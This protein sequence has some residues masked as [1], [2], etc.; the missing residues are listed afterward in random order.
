MIPG[1]APALTM[2]AQ[3][4]KNL[5]AEVIALDENENPSVIGWSNGEDEGLWDGLIYGFLA[6]EEVSGVPVNAVVSAFIDTDMWS[7][8]LLLKDPEDMAGIVA[9]KSL[10]VDGEEL[11]FNWGMSYDYGFPLTYPQATSVF[12]PDT[13]YSVELGERIKAFPPVTLVAGQIYTSYGYY[14]GLAGSV[15]DAYGLTAG[16]LYALLY[17]PNTAVFT[18]I[19]T[20]VG[21]TPPPGDLWV[22]GTKQPAASAWT[23]DGG[24]YTRTFTSSGGKIFEDGK[25]YLV[26]YE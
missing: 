10:F 21:T 16:A 19:V 13:W 5:Y 4:Q 24:F 26:R 11:L 3:Q 14:A 12:Q 17:T 6:A 1:I 18:M 20:D 2:A 9:D 23:L 8:T 25:S 15:S 7:V 22:D